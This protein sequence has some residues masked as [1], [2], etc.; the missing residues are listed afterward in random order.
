M[1]GFKDRTWCPN[2]IN[3]HC[4][5]KKG[6]DRVFTAEDQIDAEKWWGNSNFPISLF[7]ENPGCF[8]HIDKAQESN[9]S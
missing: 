6:C 2:Y 1:I 9:G 4:A 7:S 5:F 3:T 8:Q